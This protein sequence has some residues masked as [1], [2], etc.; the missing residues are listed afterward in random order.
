MGRE[1]HE[2]PAQRWTASAFAGVLYL[3]VG[4][5]GG[6]VV[7]LLAAFPAALVQ[8]VAGLALLGTIGAGL[9]TALKD[10]AQREPALI[11]FLVT[12][13]GVSL[14]GIGAAFW[15][16]VAGGAGLGCG[17]RGSAAVPPRLDPWLGRVLLEAGT[18]TA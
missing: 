17:A 5:F 7:G 8:A 3:G 10:D 16:V 9:H 12:V 6:A 14:L 15:G 2:D 4:L 18:L 1:A 13:S 11:A